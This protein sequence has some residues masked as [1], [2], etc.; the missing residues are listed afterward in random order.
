MLRSGGRFAVSDVIA[1]E[2]MDAA[3]RADVAAGTGCIAGALSRAEYER[4]VTAAGLVGGEIDETHRVQ[5]TPRRRSS[6]R[7]SPH[8]GLDIEE[9]F[10]STVL[11]E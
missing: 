11:V 10:W 4:Y 3:T 6:A 5:R 7:A 1:D 9:S 2:D 8:R